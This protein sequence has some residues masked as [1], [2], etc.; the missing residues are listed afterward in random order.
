MRWAEVCL[1]LPFCILKVWR[2]K[3]LLFVVRLYSCLFVVCYLIWCHKL[4]VCCMLLKYDTEY[5]WPVHIADKEKKKRA[6]SFSLSLFISKRN[7][8]IFLYFLICLIL[9]M[10]MCLYYFHSLIAGTRRSKSLDST[11]LIIIFFLFQFI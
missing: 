4:F 10:L 3:Y 6:M 1:V 9:T 7:T 5:V 2:H 11:K 8:L